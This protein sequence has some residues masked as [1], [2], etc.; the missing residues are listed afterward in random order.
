M[1]GRQ[2]LDAVLLANAAVD[3]RLKSNQRG[4]LCKL[5]I[6]KTYDHVS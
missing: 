4:V 2:I 1:E 3:F 5:D 6:E